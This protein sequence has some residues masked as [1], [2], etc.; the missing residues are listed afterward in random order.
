MESL[1][2]QANDPRV[3]KAPISSRSVAQESDIAPFKTRNRDFLAGQ[4]PKKVDLSEN[5]LSNY[6]KEPKENND[7]ELTK[8]RKMFIETLALTKPRVHIDTLKSS[9]QSVTNWFEQFEIL[10]R[11]WNSQARGREVACYFE[12]LALQ[13]YKL[14]PASDA[15]D[16][17]RIK[18]F[19][20]EQLKPANYK[21]SIKTLFSGAKQGPE[22][23]VEAFGT[24]LL[25]YIKEADKT[26]KQDLTNDLVFVFKDRCQP[27]IKTVLEAE[28][29]DVPF[30]KL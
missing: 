28:D 7:Q 30:E 14:I 20:T 10:T 26:N 18:T 4:P 13:K 2:N 9:N 5:F 12:D 17:S 24:R 21:C 16:Y 25:Q 15:E 29:D 22:E 27:R 1:A 23:S 11:G 8:I 6:Y 19:M 3:P